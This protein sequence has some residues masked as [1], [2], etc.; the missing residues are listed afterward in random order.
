MSEGRISRK[1]KVTK[2]RREVLAGGAV[3]LAAF[4]GGAR[5]AH[6]QQTMQEKKSTGAEE[7][8]TALH[9]EIDLKAAPHG[10]YEILLDSRQFAAFTGRSAEIDRQPG[11]AFKMF[12]GLIEGRN[13]ELVPDTRIVQA[14]RPANWDPGVYSLVEFQLK[15]Q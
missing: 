1:R 12:G 10:I 6:G 5:V 2:T 13:I 15:A 11:G 4:V 8:I 7:K 14:W 3:M 9:Q